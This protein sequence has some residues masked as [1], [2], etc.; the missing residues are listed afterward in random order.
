MALDRV[1]LRVEP[2]EVVGV[3]GPNGAGKTTVVDAVTGFIRHYSGEVLLAG[4]RLDHLSAH[5][6]SLAGVTRSFQSLELFDDLTVGDN[7]R[8]GSET[9]GRTVHLTELVWPRRPVHS[10]AANA[11]IEEFALAPLLQ[12]SPSELPYAQRRTVAIARA[13]ATSPSILML[14]EPASG[15]DEWSRDELA[16]FIRVLAKDWG[17]GIVLIEH[18]VSMV[19]TSCDRVIALDFGKVIADGTP[20]AVRHDPDVIAA[21]LGA[22]RV[23]AKK[24]ETES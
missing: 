12:R 9:R 4:R 19:L 14:D 17:M 5:R 23:E 18:D 8:T 24:V 6:R 11:A 22:S 21:Y 13:V 20:S 16:L 7:L 3:I 2:G 1:C 15:L 10:A